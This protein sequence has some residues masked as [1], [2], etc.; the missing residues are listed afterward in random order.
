MNPRYKKRRTRRPRVARRRR[1][2]S[3]QSS[4]IIRRLPL[5]AVFKCKM[6]Y[7]D[8]LQ[9]DSG[10]GGALAV[11]Q[12]S[13][14]DI[15]D[16]YVAA[17]G[18]QPR[19]FDQINSFYKKFYVTSSKITIN[20]VPTGDVTTNHGIVYGC[21]LRTVND[22]KETDYIDY[23]EQ[24]NCKYRTTDINTA[25]PPI[26]MTWS[27]RKYNNIRD[28]ALKQN[29]TGTGTSG[30]TEGAYYDIWCGPADRATN[31]AGWSF[32]CLIEYNVTW[33]EPTD[34]TRS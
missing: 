21:N 28:V 9:L 17:G 32:V 2:R 25:N 27:A 26:V 24:G 18:H 7:Q 29:M 31:T 8:T 12:Y 4:S 15:Y 16:P 23:I 1:R 10:A 6:L 30:P 33:Y 22:T 11:D 3:A 34:M 5:P 19:G 13:C 14:N 20:V